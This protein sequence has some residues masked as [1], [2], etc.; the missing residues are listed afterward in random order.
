MANKLAPSHNIAR[1]RLDALARQNLHDPYIRLQTAH[2]P[3]AQL[4]GGQGIAAVARDGA[5]GA[6]VLGR[7][8]EHLAHL[9]DDCARDEPVG[10]RGGAGGPDGMLQAGGRFSSSIIPGRGRPGGDEVGESGV[11]QGR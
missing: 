7:H 2:E 11:E 8:H 5:Q 6:D 3:V 4:H 1:Q 9:L 10:F